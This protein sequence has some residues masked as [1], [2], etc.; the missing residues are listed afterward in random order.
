MAD[1]N[2]PDPPPPADAPALL[3]V[4]H[5]V[6]MGDRI[7]TVDVADGDFTVR[8]GWGVLADIGGGLEAT[9]K[10]LTERGYGDA[11]TV[12][13]WVAARVAAGDKVGAERPDSEA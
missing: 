10:R 1:A 4:R 8:S 13:R 2:A 3:S 7:Y 6:K 9:C 5:A 12:V 11:V